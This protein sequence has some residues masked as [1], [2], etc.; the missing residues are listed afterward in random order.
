MRTSP[1]PFPACQYASDHVLTISLQ[2][3][4]PTARIRCRSKH[5]LPTLLGNKDAIFSKYGVPNFLSASTYQS[6]WLTYQNHLCNQ[7]N[8]QVIGTTYE[9]LAVRELHETLSRRPADAALYNI[10]AQAHHN[11]FF[12]NTLSSLA[13]PPTPNHTLKSDIEE[14]FESLDHLRDELTDA[15]LSMFGNGY[16][17]LTKEM[18]PTHNLRILCTYNAG[19][20]FPAAHSRRQSTDAA[21]GSN[22]SSALSRPQ[23]FA[24]SFGEYSANR[25]DSYQGSLRALPI[26]CLKVWEHQWLP[27]YGITGK[28]QYVQNWWGRVDWDEVLNL[29][30]LVPENVSDLYH[31]RRAS[32]EG[33]RQTQQR[34]SHP[35]LREAQRNMPPAY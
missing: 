34:Q 28:E 30:N 27:D 26:L 11:H 1:S 15:A 32:T 7:L 13:D 29:S 20:P 6:T 22:L 4:L 3:P 23:N 33:P 2:L 5:T 14:W 9:A 19:S 17:W 12:W 8:Q 35:L 10:A 21:T 16:V 31:A 18:S 24:G 25:V